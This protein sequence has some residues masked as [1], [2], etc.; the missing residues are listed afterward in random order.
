MAYYGR[1]K[2]IQD[3]LNDYDYM[4]SCTCNRCN[5]SLNV[6]VVK[7]NEEEEFISS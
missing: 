5:Y 3:D 6:K 7:H 1:I 2:K 4:S